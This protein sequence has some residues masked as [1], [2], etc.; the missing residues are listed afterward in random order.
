M[1]LVLLGEAG[2]EKAIAMGGGDQKRNDGIVLSDECGNE[3][4]QT[5]AG[6][7]LVD[8]AV[9]KQHLNGVFVAVFGV[10]K[11]GSG[12]ECGNEIDFGT[13][14]EKFLEKVDGAVVKR[15]HDERGDSGFVCVVR[16]SAS[17][18]KCR[19]S[20]NAIPVNSAH[21]RSV[22]IE[23]RMGRMIEGLFVGRA[24]FEQLHDIRGETQNGCQ[25][26]RGELIQKD[27]R[28]SFDAIDRIGAVGEQKVDDLLAEIFVGNLKGDHEGAQAAS[29]FGRFFACSGESDVEIGFLGLRGREKVDDFLGFVNTRGEGPNEGFGDRKGKLRGVIKRRDGISLE[30]DLDANHAGKAL[31]IFVVVEMHLQSNEDR[32]SFSDCGYFEFGLAHIF[33]AANAIPIFGFDVQNLGVNRKADRPDLKLPSRI[34][35]LPFHF[36]FEVAFL[37]VVDPHPDVWI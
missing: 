13:G 29:T 30:R 15:S 22:A 7:N 2:I 24:V 5:R 6:V 20:R 33:V 26:Y 10:F 25:I 31:F 28:S 16:R 23:Q 27:V 3:R 37:M 35:S 17:S 4:G 12:A 18:E 32:P 21:Q 8:G 9:V 19:G 11:K 1:F 36:C 34:D 14:Q